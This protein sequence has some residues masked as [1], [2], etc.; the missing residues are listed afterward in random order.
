MSGR[1]RALG[2][3][4]SLTVFGGLA[5]RARPADAFTIASGFSQSCHERLALAAIAVLLDRLPVDGV[6]RPGGRSVAGRRRRA[7]ARRPRRGRHG[8]GGRPDRSAEVRA[9]QRGGRDP[10]A[11]HGGAFGQQPRRPPAGAGRSLAGQPA[12]ALP[13][14]A[15]GRRVRWRR[16]G[17]ARRRGVD[18][19][20]ARRRRRGRRYRR[21]TPRQR[22]AVPRFLRPAGGGGRCAELPHRPRAAHAAGLP[23]THAAERGRPHG[24]LGAQLHRGGRGPSR[25]GARRARPLRRPRRLPAVETSRPWSSE[26]RP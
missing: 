8:G 23:R 11:G 7:R 19:G 6:V 22:A 21:A 3:L 20:R 14:R 24:V 15:G 18:P 2:L 12:P 5:L 1:A 26:P 16:R 9:V 10:R 4:L 25:R 17:P 13:A